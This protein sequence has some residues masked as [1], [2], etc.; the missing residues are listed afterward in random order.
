MDHTDSQTQ[1]K[2]FANLENLEIDTVSWNV[3]SKAL[4]GKHDALLQR[5]DELDQEC[6]DLRER[7]MDVEGERDDLNDVLSETKTQN[8]KLAQELA[9]KQVQ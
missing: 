9:T 6:E 8:E 5:I 1:I 4:Q 7:V 3:S 2:S